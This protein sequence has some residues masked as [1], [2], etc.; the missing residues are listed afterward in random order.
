MAE[1]QNTNCKMNMIY[2]DASRYNLTDKRTG[3]ENYSFFLINEL[4]RLTP[5][6]ITLI[7]PKK[8]P[9]NVK[10]II[11]PFPRLWTQI[12]L[13][14][15]LLGNKKINNLFVPSH[16]LPLIHPKKSAIT[17]HDVAWKHL[18]ESY[19]YLS[20]WYLNWGTKY[21]VKYARKIIVPSEATKK[22]LIHFYK[23]NSRKIHIIP[24]GFSPPKINV[25]N[26]ENKKI[27]ENF[28]LKVENYFLYLGRIE[29][30][31]NT[32]ILIKA[33]KL[34]I[35]NNPNIKLVLAG[36]PGRGGKEI[37]DSIPKNLKDR[38]IITGYVSEKEKDALM[39]NALCF[40]FPSRYEGFGIPLL[41]AMYYNLPIIAS[42]IPTSY[43]I[44][45][46]NALFF[47]PA[48]TAEL[49]KLMDTIANNESVRQMITSQHKETLKKYSWKKSAQ[50]ILRLLN[51]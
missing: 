22:D 30:K 21:A 14:W 29:H 19:G 44:A 41:E 42:R 20:K 47:D 11:I 27:I 1:R 8:I 43:E 40:I 16:V 26:N 24:L 28:K 51:V 15:K 37:L 9:F 35:K 32:D 23:A 33:F 3:V 10:Q 50:Q 31:K 46:G 4:V 5:D 48:N 7:S 12:R 6:N 34:F 2:I 39:K 25:S 13:S 18:P 36:F 45:K 17:I 38:I 49:A